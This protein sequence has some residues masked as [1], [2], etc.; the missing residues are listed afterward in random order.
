MWILY[1]HETHIATALKAK[2]GNAPELMEFMLSL[3]PMLRQ[4]Q[5]CLLKPFE[6]IPYLPGQKL[7]PL[8]LVWLQQADFQGN[9]CQFGGFGIG[10]GSKRPESG[11]IPK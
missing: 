7:Q 6:K 2:A 8:S 11:D 1:P 3:S 10:G 5:A 4:D 9:A